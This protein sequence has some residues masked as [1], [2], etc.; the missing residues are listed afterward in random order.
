MSLFWGP[1]VAILV[2][3]GNSFFAARIPAGVE[4]D[5]KNPGGEMLYEKIETDGA[6]AVD[7]FVPFGTDDILLYEYSDTNPNT[8]PRDGDPF[9]IE[10]VH[11]CPCRHTNRVLINLW[12]S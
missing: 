2:S 3:S 7:V 4:F 6:G 1:L 5:V 9:V 10:D 12:K 11:A 8:A